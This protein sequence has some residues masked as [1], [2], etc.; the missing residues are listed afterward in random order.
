MLPRM[1]MIMMTSLQVPEH[2]DAIIIGSGIGGMTTGAIMAKAGKRVLILEQH[3]QAGGCCHS[4]IDKGD[5]PNM[6]H[7]DT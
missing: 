2:L 7:D 5:D 6:T 1:K 3:D 4:F